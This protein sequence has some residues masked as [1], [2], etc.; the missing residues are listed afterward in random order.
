M[1]R[2]LVALLL[3]AAPLFAQVGNTHYRIVSGVN[4]RMLEELEAPIAT[5]TEPLPA[6]FVAAER[7][8]EKL[9]PRLAAMSTGPYA[10]PLVEVLITFA[11]GLT[12]PRLPRERMNEE[13]GSPANVAIRA[14]R[15]RIIASIER[16]RSARNETRRD[17]L[18]ALDIE[19]LTTFW[20]AD[21]WHAR[22]PLANV[23]A[24][25]RRD[26]VLYVEP[27]RDGAAPPT[28]PLS[29]GRI[30]MNS[31]FL[32]GIGVIT[33]WTNVKVAMLDTGVRLTHVQ[34]T[35]PSRIRY[36]RDCVNGTASNCTAGGT[37]NPD[38]DVWNHGTRT[39]VIITGNANTWG[40][41]YRGVSKVSIDSYK[42]YDSNGL[43]SVAAERG[44]QAAVAEGAFVIVAEIQGSG[45]DTSALAVAADNAFDAGVQVVAANGNTDTGTIVATPA[46]AHKVIGV[47]GVFA[48]EGYTIPTQ[49]PGPAP[50]NR[51]KPDVQAPSYVD[52]V[53]NNGTLATFS[54]TS[55]ATAF[56]GGAAGLQYKWYCDSFGP[57][58]YLSPGIL[59]ALTIMH[60]TASAPFDNTTGGGSLS[61]PRYYGWDD[62][63]SVSVGNG[64]TVDISIPINVKT[65]DPNITGPRDM[66]VGIWWPESRTQSHNRIRLQLVN[67]SGVAVATAD[68]DYSVFQRITLPGTIAYGT[69]KIRIYGL[70]VPAGPQTVH[71]SMHTEGKA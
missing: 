61:L 52:V 58:S 48:H 39:A 62:F 40:D 8:R 1:K 19:P 55:C 49:R 2:S 23:H 32:F 42:V 33:A 69:W 14:E 44:F 4:G 30:R 59:N 63:G 60:G 41:T 57:C 38:D 66:R 36:A 50:D 17:A 56:A 31:D 27:A 43:V 9:H 54:G 68:Q 6:P 24:L 65:G 15:A 47:G 26:D 12:F 46:N 34:L 67:P 21:V 25:A 45:S 16:W 35:N 18:R 5:P 28:W 29:E 20:L 70:S 7:T 53:G 13:E 37:L 64:Q 51:I 3:V 71:Y 11:D 22:M 10:E